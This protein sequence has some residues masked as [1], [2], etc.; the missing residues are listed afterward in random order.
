MTSWPHALTRRAILAFSVLC[1]IPLPARADAALHGRWLAE[2]IGGRGV[3]D[4]IQT[5]LEIAPDGR[6]SGSGGCNRIFGAVRIDGQALAF[7][8]MG[9]TKMAC[10]SAVM[11]QEQQFLAA[12]A[13]VRRWRIDGSSRKLILSDAAGAELVVL[14]RRGRQPSD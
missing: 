14:A 2:A 9:S 11:I 6:V 7:S 1:A 8:Q 13:N 3:V 4:R 5:V 12:L 10:E